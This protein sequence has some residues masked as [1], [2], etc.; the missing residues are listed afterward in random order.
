MY[1]IQH[2]TINIKQGKLLSLFL[3]STCLRRLRG[4]EEGWMEWIGRRERKGEEGRG[5]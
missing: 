5:E 1:N 3:F 2:D 4:G